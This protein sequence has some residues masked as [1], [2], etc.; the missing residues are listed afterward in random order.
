MEGTIK[1]KLSARSK[2]SKDDQK[3]KERLS[4]ID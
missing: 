3:M 1:E 4:D 2:E